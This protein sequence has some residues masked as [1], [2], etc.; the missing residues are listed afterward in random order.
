MFEWDDGNA[1]G[2]FRASDRSN[3]IIYTAPST[4]GGIP[5][6]RQAPPGACFSDA[7]DEADNRCI[8]TFTITVRRSTA[9]TVE[10]P[11]PENPGGEIPSVLT[12]AEGRQYEVFT[13]EEGGHFEGQDVTLSADPGVVPNLEIVG[14]RVESVGSASNVGMTHQR[15]TL[16]GNRY[17][18]QAV[19]ATGAGL[20]SYVLNSP[21]ELCVP[22][23]PAASSNI[24]D[25]AIVA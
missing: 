19:D 17:E 15:Y 14:L 10:R 4:P 13:P 12:D 9:V 18:V 22:L 11:E 3:E 16:V 5:S 20:T 21:L 2:S 23:P 6:R 8:A 24:S 25:V 7:D 1:D